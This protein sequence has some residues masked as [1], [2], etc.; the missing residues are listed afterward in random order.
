MAWFTYVFTPV[1]G[2][3]RLPILVEVENQ[4]PSIALLHRDVL[5]SVGA[6]QG[7]RHQGETAAILTGS[8]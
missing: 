4:G 2:P 5:T 7:G 6:H 8:D 1:V 3:V